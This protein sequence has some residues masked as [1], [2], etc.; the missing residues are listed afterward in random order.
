M[1]TEPMAE[2]HSPHA[3]EPEIVVRPKP[4]PA[5]ADY[6][7]PAPVAYAPPDPRAQAQSH[8]EASKRLLLE[9]LE[10]LQREGDPSRCSELVGRASD[11]IGSA[12][13]FLRISMRG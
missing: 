3:S 7:A 12:L 9:A 11:Q 4:A 13:H 6:T 1:V 8:I 10:A 5:P 2:T